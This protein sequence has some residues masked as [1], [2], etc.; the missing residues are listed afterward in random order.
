MTPREPLCECARR[1]GWAAAPGPLRRAP[2]GSL[3][4]DVAALHAGPGALS[5]AAAVDA[6]VVAS[7]GERVADDAGLTKNRAEI[8]LRPATGS[9][10]STRPPAACSPTK[11]RRK[12]LARRHLALSRPLRVAGIHI[13][14]FVERSTVHRGGLTAAVNSGENPRR[15]GRPDNDLRKSGAAQGGA[16]GLVRSIHHVTRPLAPS[17]PVHLSGRLIPGRRNGKFSRALCAL[18]FAALCAARDERHDG[19]EAPRPR[20]GKER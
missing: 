7:L 1:A 6:M 4:S 5:V 20:K 17:P 19:Q 14:A 11:V 2:R 8:I 3:G 9:L 16:R 12:P 13:P 15:S 18:F 10:S